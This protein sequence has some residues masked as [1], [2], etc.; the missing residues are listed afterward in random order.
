M[1]KPKKNILLQKKMKN[2]K[3]NCQGKTPGNRAVGE[4]TRYTNVA[5]RA[6]QLPP[7]WCGNAAKNLPDPPFTAKIVRKS[8]KISENIQKSPKISENLRKSQN[9]KVDRKCLLARTRVRFPPPEGTCHK[10]TLLNVIL[11]TKSHTCLGHVFIP[12]ELL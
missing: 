4:C 1:K 7:G 10:A 12:F 6:M 9:K 2:K 11:F 5:Q 3:Y 8:P